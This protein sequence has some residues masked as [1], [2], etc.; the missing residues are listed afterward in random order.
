M[1]E[2][3]NST[4]WEVS[5]RPGWPWEARRVIGRKMCQHHLILLS[6][7]ARPSVWCRRDEGD[8][9]VFIYNNLARVGQGIPKRSRQNPYSI[10]IV[11]GM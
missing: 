4:F 10:N 11:W 7:V 5:E 3:P 2:T 9:H 8:P 6:K 1:R